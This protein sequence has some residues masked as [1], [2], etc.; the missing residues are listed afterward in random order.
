MKN[1]IAFNEEVNFSGYATYLN[2]LYM[3]LDKKYRLDLT[4]GAAF[5]HRSLILFDPDQSVG[6]FEHT[7][8]DGNY[9]RIVAWKKFLSDFSIEAEK[10]QIYI[11]NNKLS[12]EKRKDITK[13]I[14]EEGEKEIKGSLAWRDALYRTKVP[15]EYLTDMVMIV[16]LI[17]WDG[18]VNHS[19]KYDVMSVEDEAQII[20]YYGLYA[21]YSEQKKR[22][23][24]R[25]NIEIQKIVRSAIRETVSGIE[26]VL[27]PE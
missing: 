12:I 8:I 6:T 14:S 10:A 17:N 22:Y 16:Y 11:L 25:Y 9:T 20:Y 27:I 2:V 26:K 3:K 18:M 21:L 24:P 1:I 5:N 15:K 19:S 7:Y 23:V 4:L 13:S